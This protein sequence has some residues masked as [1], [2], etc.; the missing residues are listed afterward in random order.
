VNQA[1]VI[2]DFYGISEPGGLWT[3]YGTVTD[4]DDPVQGMVVDF[5]GVL[6]NFSL[7]A[8]VQADGTFSITQAFAGLES[9]GATAQT[10]DPH[11]ALSNV[12]WYEII[13]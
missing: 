7:T 2:S 4:V 6:A 3:F 13:V 8:T 10:Q 5:G 9:G 1:P 11:G 12:A